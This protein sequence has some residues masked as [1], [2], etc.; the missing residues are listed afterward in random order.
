MTQVTQELQE[1]KQADSQTLS[2]KEEK[3]KKRTGEMITPQSRPQKRLKHGVSEHA[4]E[5]V[6]TNHSECPTIGA[7]SDSESADGE[8]DF[9]IDESWQIGFCP[10]GSHYRGKFDVQLPGYWHSRCWDCLK[11]IRGSR[12]REPGLLRDPNIDVPG[13][14]PGK[15]EVDADADADQP[16]GKA[17][18]DP[19][20][21]A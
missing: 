12:P 19:D 17:D 10:D 21:I 6:A 8:V 2:V 3:Q 5:P 11:C 7:G 9:Y 16:P 14:P 1:E 18:A 13:I 4:S 15:A 20:A